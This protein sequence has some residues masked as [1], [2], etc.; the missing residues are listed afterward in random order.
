MFLGEKYSKSIY[1]KSRLLLTNYIATKFQIVVDLS[2]IMTQ[3]GRH[4]GSFD[5]SLGQLSGNGSHYLEIW[6]CNYP[7]KFSTLQLMLSQLSP[8]SAIFY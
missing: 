3:W 1:L 8:F 7:R 5:Q 2:T 6:K 4:L